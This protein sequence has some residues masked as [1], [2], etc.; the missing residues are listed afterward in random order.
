MCFFLDQLDSITYIMAK[1]YYGVLFI[2]TQNVLSALRCGLWRKILLLQ[3]PESTEIEPKPLVRGLTARQNA[4]WQK[5]MLV[6]FSNSRF[7]VNVETNWE[8]IVFD[9]KQKSYLSNVCCL[10]HVAGWEICSNFMML[11]REFGSNLWGILLAQR[12]KTVLKSRV[13]SS[14]RK[15]YQ[16]KWPEV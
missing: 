15:V 11:S 12:I 4:K 8:W 7:H 6:A 13:Q 16:T 1:A 3:N 2:D 9:R 14:T 5:S 10:C